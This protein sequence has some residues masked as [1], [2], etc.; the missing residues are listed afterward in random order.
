M[1]DS[2]EWIET[3]NKITGLAQSGLHYSKDV[4]DQ[5]RYEQLL[6]YVQTLIEL[7][8]IDTK[9]F[10][11]NVL[12][13]VGYATPKMDIRAVVFKDNKI[14]LAKEVQ[15]GL[16]SVPG[17]WTDVGYSA[18]ENAE[19]KVLEETGMQVKATQLLALTDR[20]KHPH[21]SMFLHVYKAFF[22]VRLLVVH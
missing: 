6:G 3:L 19:K 10:I 1:K 15:D 4:Y 22:G 21:P 5:E 13:D 2:I 11:P 16:W 8:E 14:L 17:G 18:A 7:K 12:Q 9:D 20:R